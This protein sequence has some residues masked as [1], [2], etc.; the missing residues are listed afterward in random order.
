MDESF[1]KKTIEWI[2]RTFGIG[3]AAVVMVVL[4]ICYFG[5]CTN[6]NGEAIDRVLSRMDASAVTIG[7][8]DSRL[9]D[10]EY[11]CNGLDKQYSYLAGRV[12]GMETILQGVQ[13][14]VAAIKA[15]LETM[16]DDLKSA[17]TIRNPRK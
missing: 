2:T 5:Y 9:A 11:R 13:I 12:S 4:V 10:L 6:R 16:R 17:G 15:I 1:A 3:P 8:H 14:D 7:V